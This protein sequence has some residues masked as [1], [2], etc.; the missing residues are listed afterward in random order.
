MKRQT[1]SKK[2]KQRARTPAQEQAAPDNTGRRRFLG[3]SSNAAIGLVAIAGSGLFVVQHVQGAIYEHDLSRVHNGIPTVVQVHD[4]QCPLCRPLQRET[5]QA[6]GRYDD[7]QIDYVIANIRSAEGR[8][9]AA[10]HDVP[11]VTLLLFDAAGQ[12]T[13]TLRGQQHAVSLVDAFDRILPD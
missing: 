12:H 5:R 1:R 8:D 13:G 11:H 4:P 9:F 7:G 3:V 10:R 6:L 2:R